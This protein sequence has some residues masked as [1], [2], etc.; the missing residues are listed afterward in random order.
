[1]STGRDIVIPKRATWTD[2]APFYEELRDRSLTVR[3]LR[4][5]LEDF[6]ALD[7]IV[8]ETYM[9]AM[10]AYTAD[11][12]D[13]EREATYRQWASEIIPP[14]HEIRV[15]LGQRLLEFE[16]HLPDLSIF[17]RELRTDIEIFR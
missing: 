2:I 6:S 3:N 11:T 9:L 8:D 13:A 10:I 5:W 12:G 1:M 14:L 4:D 15:G 16:P 7:E 17:L